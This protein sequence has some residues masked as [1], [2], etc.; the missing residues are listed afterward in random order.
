MPTAD[1]NETTLYHGLFRH[2]VDEK[3]RTQ[4]PAKWRP[5]NLETELTMILWPNKSHPGSHILVLAPV[6]MRALADKI[7]AMPLNDAKSAALRRYIGGNS[8]NVAA[9]KAGRMLIPEAIAVGAQIEINQE[10]VL[11]G[12]VEKGFEIWNPKLYEVVMQVDAVHQEAAL[13]L[14]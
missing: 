7:K 11:V 6:E 4:I 9:D 8:A 12:L 14:L 2:G 10:A 5:A 1:S 3:R 13:D